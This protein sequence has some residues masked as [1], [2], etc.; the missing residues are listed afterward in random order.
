MENTLPLISLLLATFPVAAALLWSQ[1]DPA[2]VRLIALGAVLADLALSLTILGGFQSDVAGFQWIESHPWIPSIG[3]HYRVGVDGISVWFLPLTSLLFTGVVIASWNRVHTLV[4]LY[5]TLILLLKTVTLGIFCALDTIL[6]FFLWELT[7]VPVYL[8][9]S[10]WG[11]GPHR[12]YAAVQYTLLMIASGIFLLLAFVL[13]AVEHARMAGGGFSGLMFS[14]PD[15][16]ATPVRPGFQGLLFFLLLAGLAPKVPIVPFHVWLPTMAREG[17]VVMLAFMTGLKLGA[18]GL[19]RFL[20]PLAPAA[21]QEYHWLLTGLGTIG[22]LFGAFLALSQTNLAILLAYASISHVGLVLLGIAS[23]NL[24][25]LQGAVFQLINFTMI[26][27]GLYFM[28]G[29][30]QHRTGSIDVANLGG[31]ARTMPLFSSFFLFFG[32]AGM[33]VP[34]TSGFPAEFMM[35]MSILEVHTGAGFAALAA[36]ILGAG[37]FLH[38]FRK[39]FLG[40]SRGEWDGGIDLLRRERS[41]ILVLSS[42]I[43]LLGL[44]PNLVLDSM[45]VTAETWIK[46]L[47]P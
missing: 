6:F 3:V 11:S 46:H 10:L 23:M 28:T 14:L 45:T 27:S 13:L 35:L 4:R 15:L 43:L 5:Y 18:Y 22:L 36:M 17:P 42:L 7:L 33:G 12:R 24:T 25:G 19:I 38:L 9:V 31:L 8:L 40:P 20:V 16:L 29:F 41:L 32:L 34:G 47:K 39:C 2:R 37:Y 21:F 1:S 26:S 44:A 30:L